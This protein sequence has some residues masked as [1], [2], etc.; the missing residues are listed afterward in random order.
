MS[1]NAPE[2]SPSAQRHTFDDALGRRIIDLHVW[3]V[4]A[5][6]SGTGTEALFDGFCQRLVAAGV[7]LWR[8][9]AATPTLHPQ[10]SGYSYTWRRELNA[11][12]P[13]SWDR[14]EGLATTMRNSPFAH[15]LSE[16]RST[17]PGS[18]DVRTMRR[19]LAGPE[20][21]LDFPVL[22]EF[23]AAGATDYVATTIGFHDG[24]PSYGTG[25][26]YSFITQRQDG[27]VDD[28]L[29]LLRAVLPAIS[30]AMMSNA[31]HTIAASLLAAYL[32]G[33]AARRVHAGA[34][35][36]GSVESIHAVLW[37][38]DL[39][40]FTSIADGTEGAVVIE[41]LDDVFETLAAALRP[42]GGEVLKFLGDGMLAIF[43]VTPAAAAATCRAALDAAAEA[44]RALDSLND[45]R[46][47][48]GKPVAAVDVALHLGE[49]LYGNIGAADRL[50]FTVI[51]PAVNE[52]ARM[53]ALCEPLGRKVL[54]SA[55]LS[56]AAEAAPRLEP[57]GHHALRGVRAAREL[58]ALILDTSETSHPIVD[59]PTSPPAARVPPLRP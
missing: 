36:R 4:A 41:L 50:D 44:M 58:F 43:P 40:G 23:A 42:R 16:P 38:A 26:G 12:R 49:V 9:F 57:L 6:L 24:D 59:A 21:L 55:E 29:T 3:A 54:V 56:A 48:A 14:M 17:T 52:V 37:Y 2:P 47:L 22:V 32:G 13:G 27:F 45:R 10:W 35:G 51:G 19:R 18:H 8:A 20:A 34:I 46:R 39:R 28:D 53:E 5:G 30:L 25:V 31:A 15:L 11:I 7:P 33:D 1:T